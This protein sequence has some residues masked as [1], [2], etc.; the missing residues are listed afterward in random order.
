VV[1][2]NI[3]IPLSHCSFG[4]EKLPFCVLLGNKTDLNHM[5]AVTEV[6]ARNYAAEN[7]FLDLNVSAKSGDKVDLVF[8]Q[9]AAA[10]CGVIMQKSEL[11][12]QTAVVTAA[13]TNHQQHDDEVHGGAVPEYTKKK[14]GCTLS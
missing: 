14:A 8:T 1:A 10:L 6:K 4:D 5:R 7:S 2:T 12:S 13:I 11:D 9:I 3:L